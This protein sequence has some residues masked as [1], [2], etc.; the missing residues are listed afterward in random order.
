MSFGKSPEL[1]VSLDMFLIFWGDG[2]VLNFGP[3]ILSAEEITV[4]SCYL[5]K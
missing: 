5:T 2:V 1:F 4:Y 3:E